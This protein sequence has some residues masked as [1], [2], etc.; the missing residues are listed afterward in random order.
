[1]KRILFMGTPEFACGILSALMEHQYHVVGVVSQPDKKVG[2]KQILTPTP[3]KKLALAYHLPVYQPEHIKD[4]YEELKQLELDCIVTCAYGQFVPENILQLAKIRCINVHASLLPKYRGGA[5]IHKAII[6]GEK[7]SGVSI[8]EMV[9]RMD[10]G[11]VCHVKKVDISEEDTMGSLH[12]K[13]MI[14]GQQALLEVMDDIL[15]NK[16]CFVSQDESQATFA[17][18]ISKEEEKIDF[19]KDG[20]AV[21]DHIRGLI[22]SPAGYA[23][24]DGK[25]VK[26]HK[27]RLLH[28]KSMKSAGE[29]IGFEHDCLMVSLKEAILLIEML[30][31]EGK[32]KM[33]AKD[34]YNGHGKKLIGKK[35]E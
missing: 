20:Q 28:E 35:F 18:N 1:M 7:E 15:A 9:K 24:L 13:L 23:Y 26:F 8:M 21:Y 5:P 2:R 33:S 34:F 22:P 14:C 11:G 19:T 10:A 32:A 4:I 31:P 3:V 6:N 27:V 12:D 29:I 25:K 17:W 30:Q 16:A